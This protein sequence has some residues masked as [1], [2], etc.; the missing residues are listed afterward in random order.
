M[1]KRWLKLETQTMKA[2]LKDSPSYGLTMKRVPV[3]T[4]PGPNEVLIKLKVVS[5]CGTDLHIYVWNKW[6]KN[7]IKPPIIVGHEIAGEVIA[8]GEGVKKVKVGDYV[9]ADS[10]IPCQNCYQCRTNR[11]H[12]CKNTKII[13]V[14]ID[15]GFAEYVKLPE[16]VVWKNDPSISPEFASVQEPFGN[17]I[18]TVFAED[19]SAKSVLITGMGPI[20]LM[21]GMVCKAIGSS[22][23][24]ATE[25]NPY[26]IELAKKAGIDY[27]INPIE[28]DVY[29]K[30]MKLTDGRGVDA[31]LEMSGKKNAL[32]DG[33][34][35]LTNGGHAALLGVF[36]DDVSLNINDSIVFKGIRLYGITGRRMFE[37][38]EIGNQLLKHKLVDLSK[39][40]THVF[41]FDDWEKGMK[42]M[43]KAESGKVILRVSD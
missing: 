21:A 2:I 42:L 14:D 41:D 19:V 38:W 40:I 26:R 33:L 22:V 34:R 13:G 10:H 35:S 23:V 11:M 9:S 16:I 3:P 28:E 1:T 18:H 5:I 12:V 29:D 17:A 15:G 27:V 4:P 7:R 20:G 32:Y 36:D 8:V 6:A 37:T 30:I 31:F 43:E 39:V 24:I 25:V